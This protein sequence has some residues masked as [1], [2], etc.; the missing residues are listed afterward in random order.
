MIQVLQ[1]PDI[2]FKVTLI[3]TLQASVKKAELMHE[4]TGDSV[5]QIERWKL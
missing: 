5:V 4:D 1:L 3:N 2:E